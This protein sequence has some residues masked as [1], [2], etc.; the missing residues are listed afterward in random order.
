[1]GSSGSVDEGKPFHKRKRRRR[2]LKRASRLLMKTVTTIV[3]MRR[4][5]EITSETR[6]HHLLLRVPLRELEPHNKLLSIKEGPK[7]RK[8]LLDHLER[9]RH[10]VTTSI[11][12]VIVTPRLELH[13]ELDPLPPLLMF[14]NYLSLIPIIETLPVPLVSPLL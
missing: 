7:R 14:D 6:N 3:T 5:S 2:I 11:P 8:P 13:H 1:L 12:R 10:W 4:M 9:N